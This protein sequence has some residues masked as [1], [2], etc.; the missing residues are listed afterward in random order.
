MHLQTWVTSRSFITISASIATHNGVQSAKRATISARFTQSAAIFLTL[1]PNF[2]SD[3]KERN[4]STD[5]EPSMSFRWQ[6]LCI[7]SKTPCCAKSKTLLSSN[8]P[9]DAL[10]F[11]VSARAALIITGED[12]LVNNSERSLLVA[13]PGNRLIRIVRIY[14]RAF[15]YRDFIE[16]GNR[17]C[18]LN[19]KNSIDPSGALTYD[20]ED[21]IF[22]NDIARKRRLA[23]EEP[24][25][26]VFW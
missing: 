8:N 10:T 2:D 15:Y 1:S 13:S 18:D 5:A 7:A 16:R 14:L 17:R 20:R 9:G 22:Q 4:N 3:T 11:S 19:T 25:V 12:A 24:K 21:V 23:K 6:A 26:L